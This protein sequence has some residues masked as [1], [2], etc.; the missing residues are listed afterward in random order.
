[1]IMRKRT[2]RRKMRSYTMMMKT[3]LDFQALPVYEGKRGRTPMRFTQKA[4]TL[5]AG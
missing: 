3:N 5:E 1:M 2:T 4:M